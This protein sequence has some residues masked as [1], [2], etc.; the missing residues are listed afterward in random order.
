[1]YIHVNNVRIVYVINALL[2]NE[3]RSR[4]ID[5]KDVPNRYRDA[6]V[7]YLLQRNYLLV[8]LLLF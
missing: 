2:E 7:I 3:V 8:L 4:D 6:R 5:Q 1:M